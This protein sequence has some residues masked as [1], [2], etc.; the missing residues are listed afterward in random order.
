MFTRFEAQ[1]SHT[2]R[3][4]GGR[5]QQLWTWDGGKS[6]GRAM[7]PGDS[8]TSRCPMTWNGRVYFIGDRDLHMNLWTARPDG[9][10]LRQLTTHK[11]LDVRQAALQVAPPLTG[12]SDGVL[13]PC[14]RPE[15]PI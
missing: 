15:A 11:G 8:A 14:T 12:V 10:D 2:K 9:S 1:P 5:V 6:E 13:N 7:F 4:R 3:Y